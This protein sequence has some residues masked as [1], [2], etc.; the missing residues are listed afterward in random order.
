[1]SNNSISDTSSAM[2]LYR[3]EMIEVALV[4]LNTSS[5]F[6]IKEQAANMLVSVAES[7]VLDDDVECAGLFVLLC[8]G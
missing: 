2:R 5:V 7:G 1:M 6:A 3:K 4:T 8:F